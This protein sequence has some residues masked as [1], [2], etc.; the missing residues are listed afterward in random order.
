M[1]LRAWVSFHLSCSVTGANYLHKT[2]RW[3][4]TSIRITMSDKT[5]S[6]YARNSS[7]RHEGETI[8]SRRSKRQCICFGQ[9]NDVIFSGFFV[10]FFSF[11]A[12][13]ITLDHSRC[14]NK[15]VSTT[16]CIKIVVLSPTI[17]A[18]TAHRKN[19]VATTTRCSK[20][21]NYMATQQLTIRKR[22]R[23]RERERERGQN[24]VGKNEINKW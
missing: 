7:R 17:D 15:I 16:A 10:D 21:V 24:S 22:A 13:I 3:Y 23:A 2:S 20:A 9:V 5:P 4:Y 14:G 19:I 11:T 18:I 12:L 6:D 1:A 8:G